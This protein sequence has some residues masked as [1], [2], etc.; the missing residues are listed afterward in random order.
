MRY[1]QSKYIINKCASTQMV[2]TL[3]TSCVERAIHVKGHFNNKVIELNTT[4]LHSEKEDFKE[5]RYRQ[6][7]HSALI[8][9]S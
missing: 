9:F 6:S 5:K 2:K 8:K 1:S 7:S 4:R 3:Q